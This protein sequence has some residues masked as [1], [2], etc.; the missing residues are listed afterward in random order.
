[1]EIGRH[2][3]RPHAPVSQ[4]L[5]G[6][7]EVATVEGPETVKGSNTA[8]YWIETYEAGRRGRRR[9]LQQRRVRRCI[10]HRSREVPANEIPSNALGEGHENHCQDGDRHDSITGIMEL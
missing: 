6:T 8:Y 2:R 3:H 4:F 1:M 7:T 5:Y 10:P 9:R